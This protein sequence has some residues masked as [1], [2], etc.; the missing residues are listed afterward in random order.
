MEK[1]TLAEA[2]KQ[3]G[4]GANELA[5][6]AGVAASTIRRIESGDPPHMETLTKIARALECAPETID[7]PGDPFGMGAWR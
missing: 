6:R 5:R 4:F 3:R 1:P 7:W 2:R